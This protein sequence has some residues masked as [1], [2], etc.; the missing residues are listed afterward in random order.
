MGYKV[1]ATEREACDY[2]HAKAIEM[3]LGKVDD[4]CQ[5]WYE[6]KETAD[7]KWAIQC[8]EGTE[9]EPKWKVIDNV[10]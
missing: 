8:P 6:W 5:Y 9:P 4:I 10:I 1:F 2:S 7:G 3:G